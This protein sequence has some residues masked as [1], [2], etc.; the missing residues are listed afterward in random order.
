MNRERV[1]TGVNSYARELGFNPLEVLRS[2][3]AEADEIGQPGALQ[4]GWLDL[5]CG[6]GHALIEASRELE[7]AGLAGR[8]D[9]VG[10]DLAGVFARTYVPVPDVDLIRGPVASFEPARRSA[11]WAA[12]RL[13]ASPPYAPATRTK[14]DLLTA[15]SDQWVRSLGPAGGGPGLPRAGAWGRGRWPRVWI[16]SK[17]ARSCMNTARACTS[18]PSEETATTGP[19]TVIPGLF[20]S[21]RPCCWHSSRSRQPGRATRRRDGVRHR[22]SR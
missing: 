9:L 7:L 17:P 5:C 14:G 18:R 11:R 1:L 13:A 8:I 19:A 3:L 6:A 4:V 10:V 12:P 2:R 21:A 20:R 16:R 15:L 22:A